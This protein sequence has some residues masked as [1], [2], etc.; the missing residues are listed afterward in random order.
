[1]KQS[2]IKSVSGMSVAILV[3]CGLSAL[4]VSVQGCVTFL[5]PEQVGTVWLDELKGF[6]VL[7]AV[8]KIL[9]GVSFFG[10]IAAFLIKSIRALKNG[11]LFPAANVPVLY[12]S[13]FVLFVY[14]FCKSNVGILTGSEHNLLLDLD[15]VAVSLIF[16]VFA[17]LYKIAVKVSDENSLTI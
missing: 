4:F 15:D 1:M 7:V 9:G 2:S 3:F 6:Q 12:W 8:G 11:I 14:N 13:A 17:M 10:L 5:S 16:V